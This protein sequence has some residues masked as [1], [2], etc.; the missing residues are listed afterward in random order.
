VLGNVRLSIPLRKGYS[1]VLDFQGEV[2]DKLPEVL[3]RVPKLAD[4]LVEVSAPEAEGAVPA[5]D[6]FRD[7]D[8]LWLTAKVEG[9]STLDADT[10]WL[11]AG[12]VLDRIVFW[13]ES[14]KSIPF[15]GVEVI[16]DEVKFYW[17]NV[18]EYPEGELPDVAKNIRRVGSLVYGAYLVAQAAKDYAAQQEWALVFDRMRTRHQLVCDEPDRRGARLHV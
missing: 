7:I 6:K 13:A 5:P 9:L 12:L 11:V 1:S 14:Y 4:W 15:G 8:P 3:A 2:A 18:T 10:R 16:V 17:P